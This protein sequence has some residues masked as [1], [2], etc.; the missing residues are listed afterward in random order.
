MKKR[1][2]QK[3][4]I[5]QEIADEVRASDSKIKQSQDVPQSRADNAIELFRG[6]Q[7]RGGI[8]DRAILDSRLNELL[9]RH[10]DGV[11][12]SVRHTLMASESA[13]ERETG[14]LKSRIY[15]YQQAIRTLNAQHAHGLN[16][17]IG[18]NNAA[19][20]YEAKESTR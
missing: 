13:R 11:A 9:K 12:E 4:N 17:A 8:K 18:G 3:R 5:V 1:P 2:Q 20:V 7:F 16:E 14:E 10:A 19:C 6:I 15:R